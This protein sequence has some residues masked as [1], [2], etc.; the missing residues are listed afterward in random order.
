MGADHCEDES[1]R[2]L[3]IYNDGIRVLRYGNPDYDFVDIELNRT[4]CAGYY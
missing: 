2:L 4:K 3:Y 1:D